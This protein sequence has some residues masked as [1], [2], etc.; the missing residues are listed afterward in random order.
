MTQQA[1]V[2]SSLTLEFPSKVIFQNLNFTLP[3]AQVSALIGRNGQGKSLLMQLLHQT[4]HSSP[5][6]SGQVSWQMHH[7]YLP[8]L[9]RLK[10]ATIAEALEVSQLHRAFKNVEHGTASFEDYELLED[11]WHLPHEWQQLLSSAQLPTDLDFPVQYLSEGQKTKLALCSLFLKP[12]YYLLLDEPSNHLDR[13]A[14]TWLIEHLK[15]H[16]AGALI[17]S[18][19]RTFLDQVDHIYYLNEH[20]LQHFTGNYAE[21]FE[22]YQKNVTSLEQSIQQSQRDIKQMKH[23]QH[24]VLMKAQK[25]ER[26]GNKLRDSNSQA[27]VLLDFKKEQAGQSIGKVQAQHQRQISNEQSELKF[28]KQQLEKIKPQLFQFPDLKP[29]SGEILR[30]KELKLPFGTPQPVNLALNAREKIHIAGR[31]GI[32]KSTLLKLIAQQKQQPLDQIFLARSCFYL[33]QNFG[34]LNETLSAIENLRQINPDIPEVEWRNLLGQLRIR[35]DKGTYPLSQLSGGEKLKVALLGL[36]QV[37]SQPELLLL[38]EPENH[39]DIESKA[40]LASAIRSYTGA[41]ILVSHD[42][43]FVRDCG[44]TEV[45]NMNDFN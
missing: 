18:H 30:V 37:S 12:E 35:G 33:D 25:R 28:Q 43:Q 10:A 8:Q 9:H 14:R 11:S 32:G 39:L 2:I 19:D 17:I 34:F 26:A 23:K 6:C 1:C 36:S 13:E 45:F 29:Q 27:K 16:P 21:F 40:L 38:D 44:I 22:Q 15:L 5:H 4:Q 3:K 20:G 31:N 41:V 7:A 42:E 24:D